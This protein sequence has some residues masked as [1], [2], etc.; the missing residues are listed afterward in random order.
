MHKFKKTDSPDIELYEN[1]QQQ[2]VSR[3][4][5]QC[6]LNQ[7]VDAVHCLVMLF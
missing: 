4:L 2:G 7:V 6:Y 5:I 3:Q 1:H